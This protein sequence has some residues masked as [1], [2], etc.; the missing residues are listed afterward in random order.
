MVNELITLLDGG[1]GTELRARGVEVPDHTTSIWSAKALL[2]DPQAIVAVHRDYIEAGAEVITI[3]NYML[4]PPLLEREGWAD[5]LEELTLLAVELAERARDD[6]GASVRIAGSLPPLETSYRADEDILDTYRRIAAI[7]APRVEILL[8]ETMAS[9]REA[10]AAA[11]AATET[12]GETWL[13]WTMQGHVPDRLPSG[14]AL[15]EVFAM[16]ASLPIAAYLVNCCAANFITRSMPVLRGLTEAP[17]GGYANAVN[18][19]TE[20][21]DPD[22]KRAWTRLD[23]T[24]Y[25][26]EVGKWIEAGAT[27]VG[28]CCSTRPAH[29]AEIRSCWSGL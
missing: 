8:C 20:A 25:A 12:G 7:L 3:N 21:E 27:L 16:V 28:G 23:P 4:T 18:F 10:L 24:A 11:T 26:A 9:G 29:I 2:A 22:D 1:M 13:S 5:Q 14:E 15:P 19:D 6:L 17:I